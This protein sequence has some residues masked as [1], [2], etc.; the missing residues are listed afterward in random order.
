VLEQLGDLSN[1]AEEGGH[2]LVEGVT[3]YEQIACARP[4]DLFCE[5]NVAALGY[6]NQRKVRLRSP[7][8]LDG[9]RRL[10]RVG[11]ADPLDE[12]H[13]C[14]STIAA[15][16]DQRLRRVDDEDVVIV[17]RSR[18]QDT[19]QFVQSSGFFSDE[20]EAKAGGWG[21]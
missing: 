16:L 21:H 3:E 6:R 17:S 15:A 11:A 7:D 1:L 2:A 12:D 8:R 18:A 10:L 4:H 14:R 5:R 13:L 9:S 19:D 20:G